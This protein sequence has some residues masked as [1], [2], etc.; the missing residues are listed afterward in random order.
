MPINLDATVIAELS[1]SPQPTSNVV[2]RID[3]YRVARAPYLQQ[4]DLNKQLANRLGRVALA[5]DGAPLEP[6]P[7]RGTFDGSMSAKMTFAWIPQ[8]ACIATYSQSKTP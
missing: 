3:A 5:I 7:I 8:T 6:V 2:R 1:W 4:T